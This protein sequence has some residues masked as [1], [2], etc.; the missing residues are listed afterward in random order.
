[1]AILSS[2]SSEVINFYALDC[3][4]SDCLEAYS[5]PASSLEQSAQASN[6][7]EKSPLRKSVF[8]AYKSFLLFSLGSGNDEVLRSSSYYPSS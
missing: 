8:F 7:I 6:F 3:S 5:L 2:D 4:F 1:M